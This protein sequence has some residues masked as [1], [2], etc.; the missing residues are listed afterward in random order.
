MINKLKIVVNF[1]TS[2]YVNSNYIAHKKDLD[3]N[4]SGTNSPFSNCLV[5]Q[6]WADGKQ[7]AQSLQGVK[8]IN[9]KP[10]F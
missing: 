5:F 8:D 10:R 1:K 7:L 9:W 3:A 4:S 2:C 6:D